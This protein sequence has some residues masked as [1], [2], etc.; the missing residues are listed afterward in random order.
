M[1]EMAL[2]IA[3]CGMRPVIDRTFGFEDLKPAMTALKEG[4]HMGKI[5][6]AF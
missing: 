6:L 2:A 4:G 3:A 1:E 5:A